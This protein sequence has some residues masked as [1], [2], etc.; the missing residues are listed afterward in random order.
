M[1]NVFCKLSVMAIFVISVSCQSQVQQARENGNST[2]DH[3]ER[4]RGQ[5]PPST[6]EVMEMMDADKDGKL[7]SNEVR[8]PLQ[9]DFSNID[10]DGDGF[11]TTEELDNAPRR[12][13]RREGG[14]RQGEEGA[15][16]GY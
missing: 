14:G 16:R 4:K 5:R 1:K 8:G 7:G 6:E 9:R 10:T 13:S 11:L 15:S 2:S 3:Q 12:G